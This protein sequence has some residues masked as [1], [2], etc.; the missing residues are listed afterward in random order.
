MT[1]TPLT[2]LL[3]EDDARLADLTRSYLA[4]HGVDVTV[5]SDGPSG[6]Q[7]ARRAAFDVVLLDLM[8]PGMDGIEICTRLRQESDVPVIMISARGEEADRVMGLEIGAD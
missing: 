6:L 4:R 8:L 1:D 7:L 5:V 3:V 2:A